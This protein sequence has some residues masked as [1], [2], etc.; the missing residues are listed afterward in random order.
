MRCVTLVAC[1]LVALS[2][3]SMAQAATITSADFSMG[4]GWTGSAFD[5]SE[6]PGN[7]P[8]TLGDFSLAAA[9]YSKYA[10][11]T[12]GCSFPG[13][14]LTSGELGS[15]N[16]TA[17]NS[18]FDMP[19]VASYN[20]AAPGDATATPN[21]QL[22]IELTNLS[23]YGLYEQSSGGTVGPELAW[24]EMTAGHLATSPSVTL[25][26]V[27]TVAERAWVYDASKY[28]QLAWD[29]TIDSWKV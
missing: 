28:I 1:L 6:N 29:E 7:S 24:E 2:F 20:G 8:T 16:S 25:N 26:T 4:Y 14:T 11:S 23:V 19:I 17:G 22:K 3:A 12:S 5:G 18:W 21:Y 13:L 15:G 27:S 10:W 9:P